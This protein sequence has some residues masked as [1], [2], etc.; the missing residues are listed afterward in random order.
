MPLKIKGKATPGMTYL[1]ALRAIGREVIFATGAGVE[2]RWPEE[3][4]YIVEHLFVSEDPETKQFFITMGHEVAG[5]KPEDHLEFAYELKRADRPY[6]VRDY[7]AS[8]VFQATLREDP[9]KHPYYLTIKV[10]ARGSETELTRA[11]Y[12][13]AGP[14]AWLADRQEY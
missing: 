14:G 9:R 3:S 7:D 11:T 1:G 5:L 13:I 12:R 10:R 8:P 4:D 6:F 2:R